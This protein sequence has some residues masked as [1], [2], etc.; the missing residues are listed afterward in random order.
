MNLS[1]TRRT[2]IIG[3]SKRLRTFSSDIIFIWRQMFSHLSNYGKKNCTVYYT[4]IYEINVIKNEAG[5]WTLKEQQKDGL[6]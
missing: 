3:L 4:M 6:R 2:Q 1:E 5:I